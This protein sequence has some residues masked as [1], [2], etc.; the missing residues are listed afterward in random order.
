[1]IRATI[2]SAIVDEVLEEVREFAYAFQAEDYARD[3]SRV[4]NGPLNTLETD[5]KVLVVVSKIEEIIEP[6]PEA[7]AA[8]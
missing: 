5:E 2:L 1:M 7:G 4:L 8:E 6:G 3:I